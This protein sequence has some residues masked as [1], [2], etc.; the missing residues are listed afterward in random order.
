MDDAPKFFDPFADVTKTHARLPHWEQPGATYFITFNMADSIPQTKRLRL[1]EERKNWHRMN[2]EPWAPHQEKEYHERFSGSVE[3]W[4]DAGYGSCFLRDP[5]ATGIV[6]DALGF[7]DG[8][9]YIH[10]TWVVMPNHVHCLISLAPDWPLEKVL[11]S[12]KSFT[13]HELQ[14]LSTEAPNPFWHRDYFDRL[15]RDAE[16]FQNCLRY[17][18]R[19]PQKANLRPG[20]FRLYQ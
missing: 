1:E 5:E 9:R 12:W 8:K 13:S 10:H 7:F 15:I 3:R 6:A 2:P 19:N 4:L 18:Q 14:K 11:H 16:H 20:Q 17:I